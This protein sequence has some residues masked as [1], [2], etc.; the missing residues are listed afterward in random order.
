MMPPLHLTLR[1][2]GLSLQVLSED[3]AWL[4]DVKQ[5]FGD[6]VGGGPGEFRIVY[7]LGRPRKRHGNP[8]FCWPGFEAEVDLSSRTAVCRGPAAVGHL[9]LFLQRLLAV[10]LEDGLVLHG[11]ALAD[12]SYG[13]I[14][15]GPSGAGKSTIASLFPER[16][17]CDELVAVRVT[18]GAASVHALPFYT[19]RPGAARLAGILMLEHGPE[20][21]RTPI[22]PHEAMRRLAQQVLWPGSAFDART[23]ATLLTLAE[24]VPAYMLTFRPDRGVWPVLTAEAA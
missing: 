17:L 11:A 10:V 21:V 24:T 23:A 8:L 7:R 15:S 18:R 19:S 9:E 4:G 1:L 14:C 13:W 20:H 2:A 22:S 5:R 3:A 6:F 12:E 16:A